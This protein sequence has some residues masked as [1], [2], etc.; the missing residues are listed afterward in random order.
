MTYAIQIPENIDLSLER[1][2]FALSQLGDPHLLIPPTLHVAGTNGK[3]STIAFL[4]AILEGEG[5]TV[6]VFTSPHLVCVNER[7]VIAGQ[8]IPDELLGELSHKVKSITPDLS[9][10]EELTCISFLAFSKNPADYVLFEVGLGGRLD[11]TNVVKPCLSIIT[12]ISLDHQDYLGNT[13]CDIAQEKAGIIKSDVPVIIAQQPYA[14]ALTVLHEAA[15][16]KQSPVIESL[17]LKNISLGLNG[18]HQYS[19]AATAIATAK[20]LFGDKD[21]THH[22]KNARWP[23]RLQRLSLC[24]DI[25]IDGAHNEDGIRQIAKEINRWKETGLRIVLCISQL[26]NRDP[27]ILQLAL[28]LADEVIHIDMQQGNRFHPK[29]DWAEKSF[30]PEQALLH[31]REDAYNNTRILFIGSLYMIGEILKTWEESNGCNK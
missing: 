4:R 6:H 22:L 5:K 7:I 17:P 10:F 19:N 31:F 9:Y 26:S 30:T 25:W 2:S 15:I 23:G 1:I 11:A 16:K 14:E 13:I 20:E 28:S 3:G 21:Y 29:S 12:S 8:E 27:E 18:E 24:P